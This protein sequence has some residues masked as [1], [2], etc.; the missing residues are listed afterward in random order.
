MTRQLRRKLNAALVLASFGLPAGAQI[1]LQ[2][3]F[4]NNSSAPIGTYQG[5]NFR[6]GGFSGLYPIQGTN[7]R[8][9][10]TVSD[11]GVNIDGANANPST[12][13]PAYDKIFPFANYA[14]KIHRIRLNGDSVQILR[15][16]TIKR[17]NNTNTVGGLNPDGFGSTATE[18]AST[19]TV[20]DCA[21]F[22]TKIA[23]KDIWAMD[24][25]AIVVDKNG[26]F[27]ISEEN[28]PTIWKLNPNGVVVARYSPYANLAGAQAQ[29]IQIDTVFKYR[30]NNRGFENLAITP[31][32]KIYAVIQSPILFPTR[33]VGEA[34]RIHRILELDPATGTMRM[35]AYVNDGTIGTSGSNQIRN[36]D[37]KLGDIAAVNDSTFLIL[38][39]AARGTSDYKRMYQIN[40]NS[41]TAVTSGRYGTN[42]L[43][44]LVD[45]ARLAG[46]SIQPVRKTLFMDLLANGWPASLDKAEGLAILNDSTIFIGN[47]NDY[48]QTSPAANG[49]ATA[50]GNLSHVLRFGLQGTNKLRNFNQLTTSVTAGITGPS[51]SQSPYLLPT[52]PGV[53]FTSIIS[54][55]E[56][57]NGYK[58]VGTPDGMGAYDNNN[59]TFTVLVNHEFQPTSGAVHA[60]GATG[61]FVSRW[62]INKSDLRVVSG[63]DL[64][65]QVKLWNPATSSYVTY[66]T[67]FPAPNSKAAFGRHCSADLPAVTAFYNPKTGKGTRSRIFMNGEETGSE[68]RGLAYVATGP[69][70]GT[71]Y[72]VPGLGKYSY[73]NAVASPRISDTTVVAGLD[74]ENNGQV[75]FYVGTK[76]ATGSEVEKAGLTGGNLW[77]FAVSGMSTET[78]ASVPAPNTAFTMINLG[79]VE[80]MTGST[81][82]TNSNNNGVSR[83]MRPEDGTWDPQNPGDFYFNT[84]ASFGSTSRTWRMRFTDPGNIT[85]GGTITAVLD[86][87]EG[88]QMLDNI[89]IDN[90][91]HLLHV[92]DVGG[93][94][95]LGRL[96]QYNIAADTLIQLAVHDS[97]RFLNGSANFLTQDE[98]ASG[99][100]DVQ[101]ILGPG[102]FMI[103]DQAH[104]AISGDVVEGGQMLAFYNPASAMT[105][106]E[107]ALKGNNTNIPN[108]KTTP[109][110]SDS[111]DFGYVNSGTTA[112]RTYTI[113]NAGPGALNV[114]ELYI[115]G[116]N[117]SSFSLA[118]APALP[119][120]INAG[121]TR[122]VQVRFAPGVDGIRTANL[123]FVS[124]D[125]DEEYFAV[126]LSGQG[127]SPDVSVTG[128]GQHISNG[129]LTPGTANN[130][131]FGTVNTGT[132][133]GKA[134]VIQNT[135]L[136]TLTLDSVRFSGV[137]AAEFSVPGTSFPLTIAAGATQALNVQFAPAAAGIRTATL[138]ISSNDADEATYTFALQG[139]GMDPLSVGSIPT[140]NVVRLFP[141]PTGGNATIAMNLK[142]DDRIIVRVLNL[143]GKRVLSPIDQRL[144]AGEQTII[145]PTAGLPSGTYFVEVATGT[146][147]LRIQL[148]VLH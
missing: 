81:L 75:Y 110:L 38:E 93:N 5:I 54:A 86:G 62:I 122:T 108:N 124:N 9:F 94:A 37:W 109:V 32:G 45:S 101:A 68:G 82:Q 143:D 126:A 29:D 105:N 134:F 33:T 99:Q 8:E 46:Q 53:T 135:G 23:A 125:L 130:T 39:A 19:D 26:Y 132:N 76:Q 113:E 27:W 116:L 140:S 40:I 142:K 89:C 42:T 85:K 25:E 16:I 4:K 63:A 147:T 55:G 28:G 24:A 107:V 114:R 95:H 67:S 48:G 52:Q 139:R 10:W 128:N 31:G 127:V 71:T 6:E 70:A 22:A 14:P 97:T 47:D 129:D 80:N 144:T 102:M 123:N 56:S 43:E 65:Q 66:N 34:S 88:Q 60:H 15:T 112:I 13:R 41:A 87:T 64:A 17:P 111:T 44:G 69:E 77:S 136:G 83:F 61:A 141:N 1:A 118:G 21:N 20:N 117:A 121:A 103:V 148:V 35:L 92:E 131:D 2:Q 11:R 115:D 3:D 50:T 137:N 91:G 146:Q 12:C 59:G 18:M 119:F 49:I 104:Y 7:G 98:E 30:K 100:I 145:L 58:F 51:T 79:N 120:T 72:E 78:S 74:D 57:V 106:P 73:E 84:T 133:A 96:W 36:Q 90:G 138:A